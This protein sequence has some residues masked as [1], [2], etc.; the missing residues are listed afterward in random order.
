MNE[1]IKKWKEWKAGQDE[2]Y[3]YDEIHNFLSGVLSRGEGVELMEYIEKTLK[4]SLSINKER[5]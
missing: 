3:V 4:T 1:I 5:V 2:E